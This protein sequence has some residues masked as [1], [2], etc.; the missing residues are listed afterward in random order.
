[1][2]SDFCA[3]DVVDLCPRC[4]MYADISNSTLILRTTDEEACYAWRVCAESATES[5]RAS[6]TQISAWIFRNAIEGHK[7]SAAPS[8]LF[9]AK[10]PSRSQ[11]FVSESSYG[12]WLCICS[13]LHVSTFMP[14]ADAILIELV[15][16]HDCIAYFGPTLVYSIG[17]VVSDAWA[18][19]FVGHRRC[20]KGGWVRCCGLRFG[21]T[22]LD[23][24]WMYVVQ[25]SKNLCENATS[26][27]TPVIRLCDKSDF[28]ASQFFWL[29]S[30]TIFR[31]ARVICGTE[32]TFNVIVYEKREDVG[33]T[34]RT[35]WVSR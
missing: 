35:R 33:D 19:P 22:L 18:R 26:I 8:E 1:M 15:C 34:R 24:L 13:Y 7:G 30:S 14:F 21:S 12:W 5:R 29:A 10:W 32:K 4:A 3:A 20:P 25:P 23:K 9:L 31:N 17:T 2:S 28:Y 11:V 27:S 6:L 16:L